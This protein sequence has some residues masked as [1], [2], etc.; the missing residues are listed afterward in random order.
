MKDIK[1]EADAIIKQHKLA[2]PI[3]NNYACIKHAIAS[4]ENTI[5]VLENIITHDK[6]RYGI[7]SRGA[8]IE[9]DEQTEL[10]N[11]LKSRL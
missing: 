9:I 8:T 10:L 11:E 2:T 3:L 7:I 4:T 5:K 6:E 1:Q